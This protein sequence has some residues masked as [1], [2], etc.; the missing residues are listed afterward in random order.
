MHSNNQ[1]LCNFQKRSANTQNLQVGRMVV[2]VMVKVVLVVLVVVQDQGLGIQMLKIITLE[3]KVQNTIQVAKS[4]LSDMTTTLTVEMVFIVTIMILKTA[5]M[6]KKTVLEMTIQKQRL[7]AILILLL[8]EN[9]LP[10]STLLM[11]TVIIPKDRM[12]HRFQKPS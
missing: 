5:F 4:I 10:L 9:K 3:V 12:Y 8:K 7:V 6:L 11:E 1:V 2:P